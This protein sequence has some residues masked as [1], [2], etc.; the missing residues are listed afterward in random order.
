M[1]T[2][3]APALALAVLGVHSPEMLRLAVATGDLDALCIVPGIGKKTAAR[4]VIE[5]KDRLVTGGDLGAVVTVDVTAAGS[6]T[7]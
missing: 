4:L 6:A 3:S 7:P 2:A 5:L 1:P